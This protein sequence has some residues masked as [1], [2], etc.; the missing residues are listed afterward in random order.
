M[1]TP[2][3]LL[4]IRGLT[5]RYG[6][7]TALNSLDLDVARAGVAGLIGPNGAG[8]TSLLNV[9]TGVAGPHD[10][11]IIFAGESIK[12]EATHHIARRGIART[13]QHIR[14]FAN[15]SIWENVS[16]GVFAHPRR[17]THADAS[18][19]I[20][21]VGMS[22]RD[23]SRRAGTLPYGEQRRL[24]IARALAMQ[25][26]LLLLDEPAAG[27]NPQETADLAALIDNIAADGTSVL[28]IEHD[29]TLVRSV[30]RHVTVL[31]FGAVIARG[32]CEDVMAD[33]TVIEAYLGAHRER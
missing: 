4:S 23:L 8:K 32:D 20:E 1:E 30:C 12:R 11:T 28:L 14:L 27:M 6:G 9:I 2:I 26:T 16:S 25:P 29:M 24:E 15:L 10:G 5:L 31:N 19:A 13:Y 3:A 22:E 33:P 17:F 7:V 21:R 18:A